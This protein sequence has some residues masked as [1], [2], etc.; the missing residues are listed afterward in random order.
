MIDFFRTTIP[1]FLSTMFMRGD[2]G[3]A[4]PKSGGVSK[5]KGWGW[6]TAVVSLV[7]LH[8]PEWLLSVVTVLEDP[9]I[10]ESLRIVGFG[11]IAVGLRDAMKR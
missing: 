4:T 1:N 10:L 5:L 2:D 11:G 6:F 3:S 8:R 7:A 9:A